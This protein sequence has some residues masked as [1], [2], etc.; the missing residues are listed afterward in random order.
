MHAPLPDP[1]AVLQVATEHRITEEQAATAI[2][3]AAHL[4]VHAWGTYAGLLGIEERDGRAMEAWFH[5]LPSATRAAV[6][7][8]AV[9]A[10][11]D[12]DNA[13]AD[14]YLQ[15]DRQTRVIRTNRPRVHIR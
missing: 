10:V 7:D 8:D 1:L 5:S 6:L 4:T 15:K 14:I 13:L 11:V 2:E 12:A 9:A 3:W